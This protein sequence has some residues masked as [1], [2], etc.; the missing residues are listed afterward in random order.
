MNPGE[1]FVRGKIHFISN[2]IFN[3]RIAGG[4][5]HFLKLAEAAGRAGYELNF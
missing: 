3:T 4:D 5:I 2:G 1:K